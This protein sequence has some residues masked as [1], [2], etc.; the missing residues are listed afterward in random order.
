MSLT[1]ILVAS[2]MIAKLKTKIAAGRVWEATGRLKRVDTGEIVNL[3]ATEGLE[4]DELPR[5]E[6]GQNEKVR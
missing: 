2:K 6:P 4:C 1:I 5:Y 3:L